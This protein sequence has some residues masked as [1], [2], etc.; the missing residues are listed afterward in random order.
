MFEPVL[1]LG[2]RCYLVSQ[3]HK[4][5]QR[6]LIGLQGLRKR[7]MLVLNVVGHRLQ[8]ELCSILCSSYIITPRGVLPKF[9]T[10]LR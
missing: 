5:R 7:A 4:Q 6:H 1:L 2:E 8:H 3:G 10:V 9:F